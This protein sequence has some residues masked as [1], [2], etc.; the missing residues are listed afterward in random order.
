MKYKV[1]INKIDHNGHED[2]IVYENVSIDTIKYWLED[3]Q[4]S[5]KSILTEPM[6]EKKKI[7]V[8]FYVLEKSNGSTYAASNTDE[9]IIN[10]RHS[11]D[12]QSEMK[13]SE[14]FSKEVE[15]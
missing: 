1:T 13:V 2:V 5:Y 7:T 9:L 11:Y 12:I 6:P 4:M 10:Q 8:W 15:I 14:I 3:A